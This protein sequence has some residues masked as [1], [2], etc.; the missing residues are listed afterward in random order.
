MPEQSYELHLPR[1]DTDWEITGWRQ[2]TKTGRALPVKKRKVWDPL[3]ANKK[4]T[5]WGP[6]ASATSTVIE[7]VAWHAAAQKVPQCQR[8]IVRLHWAP[9]DW[10]RADSDNL[11]PLAK[12]CYDA[13]A[14]GRKDLPGLHL[15]PDDSD[16]YMTKEPPEIVRPPHPGGLWLTVVASW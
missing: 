8:L 12:A 4:G 9:G 16:E 10:R 3:Q 15:V 7:A 11:Y 6:R 13:L 1:W 14:R 2:S 5:H